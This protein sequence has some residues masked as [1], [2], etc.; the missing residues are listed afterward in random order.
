MKQPRGTIFTLIV[1]V[2]L[3]TLGVVAAISATSGGG[4][5]ANMPGMGGGAMPTATA[6]PGVGGSGDL[7]PDGLRQA[8]ANKDFI[9]INV[10]TPYEGEIAGTDTFIPYDRIGDSPAALP[11]DR[12]A[13]IVLYCR[14]GRMSAEA[15]ATLARLGYRNVRQLSGGMEAWQARGYPLQQ[16]PR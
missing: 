12:A 8:L 4:S 9:M 1:A 6:T 7:S 2:V 15:V 16:V 5:M 14:T 11:T 3:L 10:H 13:A